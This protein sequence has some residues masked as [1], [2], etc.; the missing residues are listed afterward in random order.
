M[1]KLERPLVIF[2][3]ETTGVD[4]KNDRA[5]QLAM[6]KVYPDKSIKEY[7]WFL[8]PG[9]AIPEGAS[10]VH[11]IYDKDV[12]DKPK[13]SDISLEVAEILSKTDVCGYNAIKFD[14]PLLLEEF[15][16]IQPDLESEMPLFD[17]VEE[18]GNW[19][20][21]DVCCVDPYVLFKNR[22]KQDARL[23][24][25][26]RRG[27]KL[28]D[29]YQFYCGK[30][31]EGAHDGLND[32]RAT[33]EVLCAMLEKYSDFPQAVLGLHDL[34]SYGIQ[35]Q[36]FVF[37]DKEPVFNFGKH[38]GKKVKDVALQ[39]PSYLQWLLGK[40]LKPIERSILQSQS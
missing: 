25:Q 12:Q 24:G 16:R 10:R 34:S 30:K 22:E 4:V 3:L 39:D 26:A 20:L 38:S 19:T 29:A 2:D 13:F 18:V 31:L 7:M 17:T 40:D 11:G 37:K 1:L 23:A 35:E 28:I 9:I 15:K 5:I 14:I 27:F 36:K 6:I 32:S 8:N 21:E 33:Y